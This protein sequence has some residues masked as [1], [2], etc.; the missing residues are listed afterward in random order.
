MDIDD[1]WESFM[2]GEPSIKKGPLVERVRENKETPLCDPITI[3][4]KT[5]IIYLNITIDLFERFWDLPMIDYDNYSEG[6]IKKQIKFNF[7]TKEE[8]ENFNEYVKRE[9]RLKDGKGIHTLT[10]I[11]NPNGRV[12][13]KD[14]KKIDIG[15][16]KNDLLNN[17]KNTKSAF[18]NCYVLIYRAI[19]EN[20]FKELHIKLFNTGKIE[21]P[22]I[23]ND[24]MVD[25]AVQKIKMLLQPH[26]LKPIEE[27]KEKRETILINSNF[28]CNYYINR[29]KLFKILKKKY[30]VKCNYDPCS[31]PG[32][33]CKY[34][35]NSNNEQ[36]EIS[37]MIFR[38]G[39]VLIVGKCENEDLYVIY[40]FVKN[41]FQTE[42]VNIYEENNETKITKIKKKIKKTIYI[43][44]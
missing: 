4:T 5:K 25:V 23:Q 3:S 33:Q 12:K 37:F 17:K 20:K 29:D 39:S 24:E 32:I 44:E 31:Y 41:I 27:L 34:I 35:L 10:H 15:F 11:D 38:T 40:E 9:P 30:N 16:C 2:T 36:S 21:I 22:G 43:E 26:Y 8:L 6:I 18:Y 14:I 13:F 1:E 19:I 42:Y 7:T 28:S